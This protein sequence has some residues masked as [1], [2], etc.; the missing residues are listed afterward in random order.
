MMA[1][2]TTVVAGL[3]IPSDSPF[4][5]AGVAVHV[6]AGLTCVVAGAVAMLSRKGCGRHATFGIL[7]DRSLTV[8]LATSAA[9]AV[10]RWAEDYVLFLLAMLSFAAARLGRDAMRWRWPNAARLHLSG[11]GASYIVL[12]TAFYVDNGHSLPVWKN[13]PP[14]AY[15]TAPSLVGLPIMLWALFRHPLARSAELLEAARRR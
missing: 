7:Y 2:H 3:V 11:M 12:L 13:L 6:L 1:A 4:F 9:L 8:V 14:I 15:W 10:V 5:L